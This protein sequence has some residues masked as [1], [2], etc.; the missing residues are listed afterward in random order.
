MT[1][2]ANGGLNSSKEREGQQMVP[3]HGR[4][5]MHGPDRRNLQLVFQSMF[6][7]SL[8]TERNVEGQGGPIHVKL[9][10]TSTGHVVES[11]VK[12]EVVPLE[13]GFNKEDEPDWK[14]EDFES[15]IV[16][17]RED[18]RPLL[19]GNLF[20]RLEGGVGSLGK[21]SFTDNSSWTRS[22]KFRLGVRVPLGLWEGIRVREAITNPF[23]VKD[24][25]G[26]AYKK[27]EVPALDDEILGSN[28]REK[29][30]DALVEH[31][32]TCDMWRKQYVYYADN[33]KNFGVVFKSICEL[34]GL[35]EGGKHYSVETLS[36]SQKVSADSLK[37]EA[38]A[39]WR[40]IVEYHESLMLMDMNPKKRA[41]SSPIDF[42]NEAPDQQVPPPDQ[43]LE[44]SG[45][46]V[47]DPPVLFDQ[48]APV[49][50]QPPSVTY[51]EG[52]CS[53]NRPQMLCL[54]S[55]QS[56]SRGGVGYDE[57]FGNRFPFHSHRSNAQMQLESNTVGRMS[58]SH[59]SQMTR[60]DH[61]SQPESASCFEF[62]SIGSSGLPS[63]LI[64]YDDQSAGYEEILEMLEN[65][66]MQQLL[67]LIS[68]GAAPAN[69]SNYGHP[70]SSY[71]QTPSTNFNFEEDRRSSGKFVVEWLKLKAAL[72]WGIF[73]R[74]EA[75]ERRAQL[76]EL[77]D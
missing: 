71:I 12:L 57:N 41:R 18:K 63:N 3:A 45:L 9:I 76:V 77:E 55:S 68:T 66:D 5:Q 8:F 13:G 69:A 37:R 27:H 54:E 51:F 47:G 60:N 19:I 10:D 4:N 62:Q 15:S 59:Q 22:K 56:V 67:G 52:F 39:K 53:A 50:D 73:I 34:S 43:V 33:T 6:P 36:D 28:M 44:D 40:D 14:Q 49:P 16:K 72:R 46:V 38:C 29:M 58:S 11:C 64:S 32:K 17:G 2:G 21:L 48:Q 23:V 65:D 42:V 61:M 75:A 35:I 74:K 31:A 20:V 70:C 26:E 25:R 7:N 30:W 24:R 1:T